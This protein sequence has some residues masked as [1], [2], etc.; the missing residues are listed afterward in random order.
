[1]SRKGA[2]G[3]ILLLVVQLGFAQVK[4]ADMYF[5]SFQYEEAIPLYLKAMKKGQD[6]LAV[7][8]LAESYR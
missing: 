6:S 2:V 7:V 1:M 4:E 5:D 3:A 8:H